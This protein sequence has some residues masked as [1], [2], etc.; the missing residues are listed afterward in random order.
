[1]LN[2]RSTCRT[3]AHFRIGAASDMRK[4]VPALTDEETGVCEYRPP[5]AVQGNIA[6]SMYGAQPAV[7]A[8]RS[9]SEHVPRRDQRDPDP[10]GKV[11][12]LNPVKP[13]A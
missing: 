4:A 1:M 8:T 13:A 11:R 3:C 6:G 7:H 9:C 5:M 2:K 10:R 12:H